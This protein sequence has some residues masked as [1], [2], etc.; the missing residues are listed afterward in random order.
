M[1]RAFRIL[2]VDDEP[3]MRELVS[4]MLEGGGVEVRTATDG[5]AALSAARTGKPDLIL[6]DIVLPGGLDGVAVCRMLRADPAL[7]GVPIHMLTSRASAADRSAAIRAGA[8]G[9]IE[10]PFKGQALQ[11]LVA[12]L[13]RKV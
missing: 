8:D 9:Y 4:A 7:R 12:G 6:L 1:A 10:K 13:R 11:D 3:V 5:P 2:M